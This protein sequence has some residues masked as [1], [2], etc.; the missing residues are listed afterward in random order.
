MR[1]F[2][3]CHRVPY[4]PDKGEK[5]RAWN[6]LSRLAREHEVHLFATADPPEDVRHAD[7]LASRFA[8][9]TLDPIRLS[10]R[11]V[12][13][14]A[15][16][17]T[18]LPLTLPAFFSPP[19]FRALRSR[20]ERPDVVLVESSAMA[21][22]LLATPGTPAVV[23][24]V[25]VDSAKWADYAK[26]L[27]GPGRLV[28]GRE[29]WTLRGV[30]RWL[31][32]RCAS[33]V[34]TT[35]RE[36]DALRAIAPGARVEIVRNGVDTE[37]FVPAPEAARPDTVAFF[38]V[39]DYEANVDGV[40][41]FH[42][43]ILPRL[44]AIRPDLRFLIVGGRPAPAVKA[45]ARTPGVEVTG[46]VEDLRP[47]VRQAAVCV[48]PLRIARGVQN[49]VLEALA[50]GIPVVATPAAASGIDHRRG[51]EMRVADGAEAFAATVAALLGDA[52]ARAALARAGRAFVESHY[53]WDPQSA[54]LASLLQAATRP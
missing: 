22:Y 33:S 19:I 14:L 8:S 40:V 12:A 51:D 15:L 6:L 34:V 46:F 24:L 9:V 53:A 37:Y 38:G 28:Y 36:A 31:A 49:K 25:D 32:G 17:A 18:P 4:P 13:S 54:R 50:M 7:F 20:A 5:I 23:D 27:R 30:E 52:A 42:D 47:V 10:L 39:M 11:K 43:E 45:L 26:R 41:W 21:P 48:V 44:R 2:A 1:I 29:A 16:T 3:V 35:Q